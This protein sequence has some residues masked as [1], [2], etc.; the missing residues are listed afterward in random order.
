M[1]IVNI[2]L[3]TFDKNSFEIVKKLAEKGPIA[4]SLAPIQIPLIKKCQI[5]YFKKLFKKKNYVLGQQGLTHICNKCVGYRKKNKIKIGPHHENYCLWFG[6]ISGKKQEKFMRQGREKLK[7]VFG[8]EPELYVPPNHLFGGNTFS[9]VKKMGYKWLTDRACFP[10]KPYVSQKVI[11]VP[12]SKPKIKG[13]NQIYFHGGE[14]GNLNNL[15]RKNFT[16]FYDIK[17]SKKNSESIKKNRKLKILSKIKRDLINGFKV[18][19][20]K[21]QML[22]ELIYAS[23][24]ANSL[25]Y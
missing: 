3:E 14:K 6:K 2:H 25:I 13:S 24:F 18:E 12:E 16:S 19:K 4:I 9:I 1:V 11:I 5:K 23:E 8:R 17:V 10:M 7:K 22:A 21:T 20:D 15:L